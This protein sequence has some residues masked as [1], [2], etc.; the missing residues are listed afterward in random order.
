MGMTGVEAD[1]EQVFVG[2][3]PNPNNCLYGGIYFQDPAEMDK[4]LSI[5]M[6]A[7]VSQRTVRINYSQPGGAGSQCFGSNMYVE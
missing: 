3:N 5:A 7:K 1:G 6:A 2:I 4:A